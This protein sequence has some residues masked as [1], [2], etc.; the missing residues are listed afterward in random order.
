M[1]AYPPEPWYLG[2]S[3]LVSVF[4]VPP[5]A[6]PP[7]AIPDGRRPLRLGRRVIVGAAFARYVPGGV[8]DYD[9]LLVAVPSFGRGGLRIT[10]TRIWVDSE[11]SMIGGRE[12]WGIPK[13]LATFDR[14]E[15]LADSARRSADTATVSMTLPTSTAPVAAVEARIGRALFP[16]MPQLPLPTLQA[17]DGTR[18][19][20]RNRVI[21]RIR[22][23][24]AAWAFDPA[25]ELGFLSGRRPFLSIAIRDA[26]IIFGMNVERG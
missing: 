24:R 12:L 9:E 13:H 17:F 21:G 3:M 15:G 1:T 2:G 14:A 22:A 19:L 16:G 20:S 23:L 6:I 5:E 11:A 18:I 25:G 10:I 7:I 4:R 26:A 8:L